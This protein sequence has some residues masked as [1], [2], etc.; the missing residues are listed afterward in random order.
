MVSVLSR[1]LLIVAVLAAVALVA[2]CA[3]WGGE[4]RASRNGATALLREGVG[5]EWDEL[6]DAEKR[7]LAKRWRKANGRYDVAPEDVVAA[8]DDFVAEFGPDFT[9]HTPMRALIDFAVDAAEER[10]WGSVVGD[11][12]APVPALAEGD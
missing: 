7:S 11:H 6:D 4:S 5:R 9:T 1:R 8:T 3:E 10:E 12:P 2:G